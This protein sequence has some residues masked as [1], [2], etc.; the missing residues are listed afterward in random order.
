MSVASYL[1]EENFWTE[2]TRS[3]DFLDFLIQTFTWCSVI[4]D[5]SLTQLFPENKRQ[6]WFIQLMEEILDIQ[7]A[8]A[9]I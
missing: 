1:L 6:T 8:N 5:K 9:Y 3:T 7:F 2:D 4:S